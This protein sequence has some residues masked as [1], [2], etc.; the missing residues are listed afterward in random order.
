MKKIIAFILPVILF[1]S[2]QKDMVTQQPLNL[3]P[4]DSCR[5]A[6]SYYYGGSGGINDSA[7]FFYT[8]NKLTSVISNSADVIYSYSGDRLVSLH[9]F[10]KPGDL[11]YH[12]DSFYYFQ[13]TILSR[14]IAHDYDMYNH[15]DTI[16][17]V[18]E[19]NYTGSYLTRLTTVDSYEGITDTDTLIADFRWT[20]DNVRSIF[21]RSTVWVDDSIYYDYDNNRNYFSG[22]S[23]YFFMAD[24][25]FGLHVGFDPHLPYFISRN[26]VHKF[27]IYTNDE[28]LIEYQ[29]DSLSHP[30]MIRSG[31]FDYMQYKWECP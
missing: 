24:P 30:T 27:T 1:V 2:C 12:V 17:S 5:I 11:L 23:R 10:E 9:Y 31:G 18:R 22:T 13:D 7:D 25:F 14:I 21:F 4:G 3:V 6:K 20:G 26:N 29:T 16:H 15:L 28:Y 19:F 8:G